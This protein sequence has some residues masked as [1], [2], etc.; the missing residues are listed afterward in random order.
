MIGSRIEVN[1]AG[2]LD[3][4]LPKMASVRQKFQATRLHDISAVIGDEFR[5]PEVRGRITPGQVVAVGCGR[6]LDSA[7][8]A[9]TRE[10]GWG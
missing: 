8:L 4:S 1:V 7:P 10:R 6:T 3:V 5:R 9:P 2:G